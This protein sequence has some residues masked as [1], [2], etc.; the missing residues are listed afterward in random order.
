[1]TD[2]NNRH[3]KD[4]VTL[5]VDAASV[6]KHAILMSSSHA[7]AKSVGHGRRE[8]IMPKLL[9]SSL[10]MALIVVAWTTDVF[11]DRRVYVTQRQPYAG[12][13]VRQVAGMTSQEAGGN[14]AHA[15]PVAYYAPMP[16]RYPQTHAPMYPCPVP[17]VPVQVGGTVYTNQAF[18]P[19]EML[20][21]HKYKS[22]Y[23]P[24]YYRVR[25]S[26]L[27]TPFGME[28]HDKW[29]LQGTEVKVNYRSSY[30]PFSGFV[31]PHHW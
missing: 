16:Q 28:S 18:A 15:A 8:E 6:R 12:S 24:F 5:V 2:W 7:D 27:W 9:L 10:V 29:E 13:P 22:L 23:P 26:W 14:S 4:V 25:G 19:H 30:A 1:M 11:A 17:N 21:P 3:N 31:P 20:Y